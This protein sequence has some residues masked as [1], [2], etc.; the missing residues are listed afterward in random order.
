MVV[1]FYTCAMISLVG[2]AGL[3]AFFVYVGTVIDDE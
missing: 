2:F 3:L 1:L